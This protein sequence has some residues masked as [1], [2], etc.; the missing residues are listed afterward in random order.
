M[1]DAKLDKP[2]EINPV[3][4]TYGLP[5]HSIESEDAASESQIFY[6]AE[7]VVS[8]KAVPIV[9]GKKPAEGT[10]SKHLGSLGKLFPELKKL[11][12]ED[13]SEALSED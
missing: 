7:S 5:G 12:S 13:L 1:L 2:T 4:N 11:K 8:V 3:A 10:S 6:P 9:E